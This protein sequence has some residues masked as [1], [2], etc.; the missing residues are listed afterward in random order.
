MLAYPIKTVAV[1]GSNGLPFRKPHNKIVQQLLVHDGNNS[2]PRP[3]PS[4]PPQSKP[5]CKMATPPSLLKQVHLSASKAHLSVVLRAYQR[6]ILRT[7]APLGQFF[8]KMALKLRLRAQWHSLA[9]SISEFKISNVTSNF[10]WTF[11]LFLSYHHF[12]A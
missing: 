1:I 9:K 11:P 3:T 2:R 12:K 6:G 4:P 7:I 10:D 8:T 5:C